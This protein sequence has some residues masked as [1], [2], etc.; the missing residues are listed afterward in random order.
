M[1]RRTPP[2]IETRT[3]RSFNDGFFT[4]TKFNASPQAPPII[5]SKA[6]IVLI[7]NFDPIKSKPFDV[8]PKRPLNIGKINP[9]TIKAVPTR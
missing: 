2:A 3:A 4:L 8:A 6:P 7:P 5:T 9:A 1:T